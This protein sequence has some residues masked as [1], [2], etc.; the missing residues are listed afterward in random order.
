MDPHHQRLRREREDYSKVL[1]N[2]Q[3]NLQKQQRQSEQPKRTKVVVARDRIEYKWYDILKFRPFRRAG[4][5]PIRDNQ[6]HGEGAKSSEKSS[7][8]WHIQTRRRQ[9]RKESLRQRLILY[10]TAQLNKTVYITS[11]HIIPRHNLF[12]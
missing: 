9:E 7:G 12:L 4:G 3:H 6:P 5:N 11:H 2:S 1:T 10:L 8:E